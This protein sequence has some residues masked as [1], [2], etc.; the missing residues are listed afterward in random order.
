M[1]NL[2]TICTDWVLP[3]MNAL[4]FGETEAVLYSLVRMMA[5]RDGHTAGHCERVALSGVALGVALRL[6]S[7]SLQALYVGGYVHDIGKVGVPDSVLFKPGKLN[8]EEW[9]I[10]RSHPACGEEI[11]RP[12]ASLH[13]VLPLIRHHHERWDGTRLSRRPARNRNP[14]AGPRAAS[15]GYLRCVDPSAS[16]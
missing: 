1:A 15:G 12:L 4:P 14:V 10:M 7:A 8:A 9:E 16:L 5:Q 13:G 2:P 6:D 3:P 11:C